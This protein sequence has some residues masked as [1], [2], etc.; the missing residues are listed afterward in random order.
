MLEV[1]IGVLSALGGLSAS[2]G[3]LKAEAD[4]KSDKHIK[5][6]EKLN[7]AVTETEAYF[8][9]R[10]D[11]AE[12]DHRLNRVWSAAS[13]ALNDAGYPKLASLAEIKG[14]YWLNPS[15]WNQDLIEASGIQ[16]SEMRTKLN[17]GLRDN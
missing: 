16:L 2:I 7:E 10:Q 1:G 6:L 5:A 14:T 15:N 3:L 17:A 9:N 8:H 12:T 11:T 4:R 13:I